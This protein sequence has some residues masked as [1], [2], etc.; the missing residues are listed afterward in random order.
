MKDMSTTNEKNRCSDIASQLTKL[1]DGRAREVLVRDVR[2]GLG[3]TAVQ[4][5]DH[6]TGV[7][8]TFRESV[9]GGCTVFQSFRPIAGRSAIDLL[10]LIHSPDPIEASVGLACVNAL[11]NQEQS[12]FLKGDV[13]EQIDLQPDDHV[14]MVGLFEPLVQTVTNRARSLTI[15]EKMDRP[16]PL[17]RP[18]EEVWSYLPKCQV[19]LFTGTSIINHTID[20]LLD[21]SCHCRIVAVLGASTPLLPEAFVHAHVTVL[22]GIV[23][24]NP[25]GI[26]QVVSEAGGMKFF[27]PHIRKVSL[28]LGQLV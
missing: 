14:A 6:R 15:F 24:E 18:A 19:A 28:L 25:A 4:L 27:K 16:H 8:Y 10:G 7:A 21:A 13:L 11:C 1:L 26:M 17:V 2:I 3:Y 9:K 23:I 20:A 12:G 22:S 5:E